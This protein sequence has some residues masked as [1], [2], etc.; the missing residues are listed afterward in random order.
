MLGSAHLFTAPRLRVLVYVVLY[1][2]RPPLP[3]SP[4]PSLLLQLVATCQGS[5]ISE[6]LSGMLDRLVPHLKERR[7]LPLKNITAQVT[8]PPGPVRD[9]GLGFQV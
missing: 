8:P 5:S 1:S 7:M 2:P 4:S 9:M 3:L 6:V